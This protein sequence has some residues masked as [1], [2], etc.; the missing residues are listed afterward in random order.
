MDIKQDISAATQRFRLAGR[1]REWELW[2]SQCMH[3]KW[4][5]CSSHLRIQHIGLIR[6]QEASEDRQAISDFWWGFNQ[7][8]HRQ[9]LNIQAFLDPKDNL[10]K[11]PM[12]SIYGSN[13]CKIAGPLLF[14]FCKATRSDRSRQVWIL[15]SGSCCQQFN[16]HLQVVLQKQEQSYLLLFKT[17]A[18]LFN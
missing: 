15:K 4:A 13:G 2:L 8:L 11:Y 12:S 5:F 6:R 1:R 14:L 16:V 18:N 17:V 10:Q 7:L 3:I 9:K